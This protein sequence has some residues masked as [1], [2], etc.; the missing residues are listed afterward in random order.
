MQR[1]IDQLSETKDPKLFNRKIN[2]LLDLFDKWEQNLLER[3]QHLLKNSKKLKNIHSECG[4]TK[5][6]NDEKEIKIIELQRS[7]EDRERNIEE[8][9]RILFSEK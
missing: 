2:K 8:R 4:S 1:V 3:E 6:S 7:I 9:E 5:K